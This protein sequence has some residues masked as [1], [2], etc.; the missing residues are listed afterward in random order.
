MNIG[1]PPVCL[2]L[3]QNASV[4]GFNGVIHPP[5]VVARRLGQCSGM[6]PEPQAPHLSTLL[7]QNVTLV[8]PS[9]TTPRLRLSVPTWPLLN[10]RT[11]F[12]ANTASSRRT[13]LNLTRATTFE[14]ASFTRRIR[15]R[16]VTTR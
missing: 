10:G 15:K 13:K 9:V 12:S 7:A 5:S 4:F 2:Q 16:A 3:E 11:W 8:R 1:L 6:S 14:D